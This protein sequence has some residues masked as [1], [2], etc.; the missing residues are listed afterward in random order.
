MNEFYHR[1][2]TEGFDED[3]VLNHF[4]LHYPEN[5]NFGYDVVDARA[6]ETPNEKALVWCNKD[7][8]TAEFTFEQ[9]SK[10]CIRDRVEEYTLEEVLEADQAAREFVRTHAAK[11]S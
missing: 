3:G 9:M 2:C 11:K 5:Y 6:K 1:F 10:M 4:E 7:G 8:E